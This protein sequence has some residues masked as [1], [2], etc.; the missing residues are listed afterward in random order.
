MAGMDMHNPSDAM[1]APLGI[2]DARAGSG[3]SW[4]P[5]ESPQAM[6]MTRRGAWMLMA[7][8]R[9]AL[10]LSRT[11]GPRGDAGV[12][13]INWVMG[14]ARRPLAGGDLTLRGMASLEALTAGR[15]GYPDLF[16]S[17]ESCRGALLHDRQ[18]PHDLL[19]DLAAEYRRPVTERV[20]FSI[21]GGPAG[22]PALGPVAFPH[23]PSAADDPIAPISHHWLDSSHISFG[24]VTAGLYGRRWKV[25]GSAFNGREPDDARYD[26][27][28]ARWD[29]SSMRVWWLPSA[30]WAVQA[31]AGHLRDVEPAGGDES[32]DIDRSTASVTYH[33]RRAAGRWLTMTLAWGAN[34]EADGTTHAALF[35]ATAD[36]SSATSLFARGEVVQ[37]TAHDLA[38]DDTGRAFMVSKLQAGVARTVARWRGVEARAGARGGIGIVPRALR[39]HYG[40]RVIGEASVFLAVRPW[41]PPSPEVHP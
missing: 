24:V 26:L 36:V 16:Q 33:R 17:G 13:G 31:S 4:L 8:G 41:A 20:A 15:C 27:D 3:T 2:G 34:R 5:D 7:H 21:Y 30:R 18:H 12:D 32:A 9:A 35:E 19:M 6:T 38:V 22:E 37:K 14:M 11:A 1:A 28:L 25:E 39:A 23:R 40:G 29:S 10:V